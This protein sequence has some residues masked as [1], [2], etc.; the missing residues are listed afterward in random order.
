[1]I[2]TGFGAQVVA[3]AFAAATNC[4]VVEVVTPRDDAAVAALCSR[5]DLD[6]ISVHSPPFLHVE[7]VRRAVE[8]GHAVHCDKPFGRNAED[9]AVM[10]E[11]AKEARVLGLLNFER[12]FDPAR[13]RLRALIQ[14]GAVGE[15]NHF[16]YAR[17]IA[18]PEA[19]SYGWLSSKELG[20][21]WLGGQGS[22]L[23]DLCRWLFGEIAEAVAVMRTPIAQRPDAN[24]EL[25][26]CDAED[27]FVASLK[28]ET[29]VTG[30]IDC[31][32]ESAVSTP[33]HTAVFGATGMLEIG[34]TGVLRRRTGGEDDTFEVDLQGKTPLIYS[35]ERWAS[36]ICDTVRSGVIEPDS[37]TFEDGLACARVM[38]QMGRGVW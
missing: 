38:D 28:T 11:L 9:S 8:A 15:P 34:D 31:A 12:R 22:H 24:G 5:P 32:V 14:D 2:G 19:R 7:H 36:I 37:P 6:L 16:Q 23:I 20:G 13:Q 27:G 21:G 18:V 35:M 30:V 4:E 33:E 1:V 10:V 3:P 29:G 17:F 25:H 26:K